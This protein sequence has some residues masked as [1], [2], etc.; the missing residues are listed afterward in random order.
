MTYIFIMIPGPTRRGNDELFRYS[1]Q[2]DSPWLALLEIK[3]QRCGGSLIN[4][5][6]VITGE[7]KK[8]F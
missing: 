5:K 4:E 3:G 2:T 6:Y 7:K 8:T 1:K